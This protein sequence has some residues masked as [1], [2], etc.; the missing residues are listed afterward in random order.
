MTVVE[1]RP[2]KAN[3]NECMREFEAALKSGRF[4]HDGNP[5][6]TWCASNVMAKVDA[7]ENVYPVKGNDELKKID[8]MIAVLMAVGRAMHHENADLDVIFAG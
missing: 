4:H 5:V 3:M 7:Q 2:T 6:L 8:G 1:Y